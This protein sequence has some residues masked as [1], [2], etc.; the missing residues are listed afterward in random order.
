MAYVPFVWTE[1][2]LFNHFRSETFGRIK[3]WS[4]EMNLIEFGV[5]F[6]CDLQPFDWWMLHWMKF[7]YSPALSL[8]PALDARCFSRSFCPVGNGVI[9]A[10]VLAFG[11]A[12]IANWISMIRYGSGDT[13]SIMCMFHSPHLSF[14]VCFYSTIELA[15]NFRFVSSERH[16]CVQFWWGCVCVCVCVATVFPPLNTRTL[17]GSHGFG[18]SGFFVCVFFSFL[19]TFSFLLLR[20]RFVS[21]RVLCDLFEK[22]QHS[23]L[24]WRH[25]FS[26]FAVCVPWPMCLWIN[27]DGIW[28]MLCFF[29]RFNPIRKRQTESVLGKRMKQKQRNKIIVNDSEINPC[30]RFL[31]G[32]AWKIQQR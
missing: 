17:S 29:S 28:N 25:S 1:N 21:L 4:L 20:S 12:P 16:K 15:I 9:V 11:N 13:R 23:K 26:S 7:K 32:I 19:F 22:Y 30:L 8:S 10:P 6:D 5:K 27:S 3:V 18:L 14:T 24:K 31:Y 2:Q